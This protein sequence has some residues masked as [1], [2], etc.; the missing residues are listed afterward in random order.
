[1]AG[2]WGIEEGNTRGYGPPYCAPPRPG[3]WSHLYHSKVQ[4][5]QSVLGRSMLVG[6]FIVG[7]PGGSVSQRYATAQLKELGGMLT[8]VLTAGEERWN[9]RGF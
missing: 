8:A 2:V 1:M 5:T 4:L 7:F 6:M 3:L 9:N